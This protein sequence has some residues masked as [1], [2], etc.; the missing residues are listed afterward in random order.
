MVN[1]WFKPKSDQT[2]Y[3]AEQKLEVIFE[4]SFEFKNKSIFLKLSY[5]SLV[6]WHQVYIS[7]S[8]TTYNRKIEIFVCVV[9][10]TGRK[11]DR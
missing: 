4:F 11:K 10:V 2:R 8:T 6:K 9:Y 5:H 3:N 7:Q 1:M